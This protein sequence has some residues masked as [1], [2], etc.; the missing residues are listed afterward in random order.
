M[1]K[2]NVKEY[3]IY[4]LKGF[5]IGSAMTVPGVSGGTLAIILN[6]YD[7]LVSSVASFFSDIKR[8][9]IFLLTVGV[10]LLVGMFTLSKL[11]LL[12]L[13]KA[14]IPVS[15]FFIG[16]VIGSIAMLCKKTGLNKISFSALIS[17]L[18]GVLCVFALDL[19]P[20]G[21]FI[22]SGNPEISDI[23]AFSIGGIALAVALIVP[24]ISF[25]H[26]LLI[27]G[28]YE[29]FYEALSSFDVLF[30][31]CIGIPTAIALLALIKLL[32]FVLRKYAAQA[33]SAII[34]F[35]LA[36]IK[37]IYIGFP[38]DLLNIAVTALSFAVGA[39]LVLAFTGIFNNKQDV[40]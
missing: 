26:M 13:D 4:A 25:S 18:L 1:Q 36:S 11:I 6:I 8:N 33:Y 24:G 28:M 31:I 34:G 32:D 2:S 35:V 14:P 10:S 15:F 37:E 9:T 21:L 5:I 39:V 27:F 29:R 12:F 17:A 30:L 19:L 20:D 23:P 22:F 16:A 38:T 3:G 40:K 7:K